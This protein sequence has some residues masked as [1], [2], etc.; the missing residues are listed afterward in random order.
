MPSGSKPNGSAFS[1]SS[2]RPPVSGRK[3]RVA[4]A[5]CATPAGRAALDKLARRVLGAEAGLVA[6]VVPDASVRGATEA[7][8]RSLLISQEPG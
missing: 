3:R 2:S 6:A 7:A 5:P 4:G 8:L 1:S